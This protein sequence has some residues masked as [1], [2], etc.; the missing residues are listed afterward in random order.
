MRVLS[1]HVKEVRGVAFLAD[2]RLVSVG[3]DKTARLWDVAAGTGTVLHKGKGPVYAVDVAP[4]GQTIAV[5]GRHTAPGTPVTLYDTDTGRPTGTLTWT[6]EDEVWRGSGFELHQ[7]REPVARAIWSLSFRADGQL[8]AAAGRRPGAANIPNGGGGYLWALRIKEYGSHL[9][10][11]DA[12]AVRF[13]PGE[14][15]LAVTASRRVRFYD[16]YDLTERFTYPVQCEWA[17]AVT[18]LPA[19]GRCV[20][21]AGSY[22]HL[23]DP[24]GARKPV[25][26]KSESRA[27][28]ALAPTPDGRSLLVGGKPGRVEVF[29]LAGPA[30]A[31]RAAFDF[32]VGGVHGLAVSP[33]G[34]TFAVAGDKG[35]LVCDAEAG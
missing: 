25:K 16:T 34:L 12:Y 7:V 14:A 28:T 26:F 20:I 17:P 9:P 21:A 1:G 15:L 8:L 24:A 13:A 31:R 30:P 27:V 23:V 18:F 5:A 2:G 6:V 33:D 32:D 4:D 10:E 19:D 29:D 3:A 11:T 35:L 22:V